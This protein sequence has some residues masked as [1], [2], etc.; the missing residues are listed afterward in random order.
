[1]STVTKL[2]LREIINLNNGLSSLS[3]FIKV[4]G[5]SA[6]QVPFNFDDSVRWNIAKNKRI[7]RTFAEDFEEFRKAKVTELSPVN[8]DIG[9]E[10]PKANTDFQ[11]WHSAQMKAVH[12]VS[13]LL[14]LKASGLLKNGENPVDTNVLE[15]LL[16]IIDD[17]P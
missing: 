12:E 14:K 8:G 2:T 1:M 7:T 9:K 6:V 10:E 13:G 5:D 15:L 16:P 3:G 4:V 11:A 17:A